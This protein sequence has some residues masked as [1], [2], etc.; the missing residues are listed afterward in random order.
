MQYFMLT[1]NIMFILHWGRVFMVK[2]S[3][4]SG[5]LPQKRFLTTGAFKIED[6]AKIKYAT[7]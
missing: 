1:P 3:K 5:K 2:M 6:G 4:T 7:L